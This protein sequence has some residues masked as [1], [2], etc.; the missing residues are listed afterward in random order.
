MII[1]TNFRGITNL[2]F[3]R[4]TIRGNSISF[5]ALTGQY[6]F[7]SDN[8]KPADMQ[9]QNYVCNTCHSQTNHHQADGIAPGGQNHN[10]G[11]KCTS[12]HFHDAG[13]NPQNNCLLC[14]NQT[15]PAGSTDPNRRQITESTPG[16][17]DFVRTSHHVVNG[18][19]S[20]QV[21]NQDVCVVCHD[22]TNHTTYGDGV[23][24]LLKNQDTGAAI[25]YNGTGT[26]AEILCVSCHDANGSTLYG[27]TPFNQ[28]GS[29]DT[30]TPKNIGWTSGSMS[31]SSSQACFNCHGDTAGNNAHGS[32]NTKL[33]KYSNY[34]SGASQTFCYNC[35]NGTVASKNIQSVFART[36]KHGNEDCQICHNQ[37]QAQSGTHTPANQWYPTT[38][39]STTNNV[40]N[41]LKG[42]TG[43]EPTWPALWTAPTTFTGQNPATK[44]YQ[45]C[46]KCHSKNNA[47]GNPPGTSTDQALEFNPN[48]KSAHPVVV[49]ANSQTG[50]YA[51]KALASS[52]MTSPWTVVGNQTMYCSDCHGADNENTT[53][54]KGPHGSSARYLLKGTRKLWPTGST[55]KLLSL[56]DISGINK[57]GGSLNTDWSSTLFCLNCH[58]SFPSSDI[59]TWKNKAHKEHDD[60][61]YKPDG[62]NTRNVYCVTCHS[63]IPHG[64]KRSRLIV[65]R[66]EPQPYT[67][68]SGGV[69]YAAII[70]FAKASGPFNYQKSNCSTGIAGSCHGTMGGSYDP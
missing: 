66:S 27:S 8:N 1:Q 41:V 68:Q 58:N 39:S 9:T 17:G 30:N 18:P 62:V 14:H 12:C 45:I 69:N 46:F 49:T 42:V 38:V 67:Y 60:R 65:Y 55:G 3:V 32:Q 40:S 59:N 22:Q 57:E 6:S 47:G 35:H 25:T 10:D 37:H 26:T 52:Q 4:N 43:V 5:E 64:N 29:G 34:T 36:Y 51:S 20:S 13:F 63:V 61:S 54:A 28:A 11:T 24:A 15:P 23:S 56:N 33:L 31:H 7:A 70:G 19:T 21:V 2:K 16:T 53:D 50:S 44:E 48:N